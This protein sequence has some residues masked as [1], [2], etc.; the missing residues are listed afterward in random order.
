MPLTIVIGS[1]RDDH[2]VIDVTRREYP[3]AH[4][5]GDGNWVF[6]TVRTHAGAFVGEYEALLRT[7]E[8]DR[9][10][11]GLA[12]LHAELHGTAT[13]ESMEEWLTLVI[14]GDGRG[15]FRAKCVARDEA[16]IGNELRFELNFDQTEIPPMLA[17]LDAVLAEFPVRG[18][19]P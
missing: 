8:L 17:S 13:F 2:L 4:D 14:E 18:A 1:L 5:S 15:H 7:D 16:G 11:A 3:D 12:R 6:A 19:K 9:F 10:R